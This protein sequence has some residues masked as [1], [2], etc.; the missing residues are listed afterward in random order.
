MRERNGMWNGRSLPFPRHP[1]AFHLSNSWSTA[2]DSLLTPP[3]RSGSGSRS[4]HS[5][6]TLSIPLRRRREW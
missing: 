1:H 3:E 4:F 2:Y 6:I 5:R